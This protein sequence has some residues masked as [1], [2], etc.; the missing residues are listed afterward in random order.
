MTAL[1]FLTPYQTEPQIDFLNS[2]FKPP[3]KH[4]EHIYNQ[5]ELLHTTELLP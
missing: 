5:E 4:H 3:H 2:N 1:R